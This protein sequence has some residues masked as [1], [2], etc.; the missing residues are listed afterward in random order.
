VAIHELAREHGVPFHIHVQE[1]RIQAMSGQQLY[2]M[3]MVRYMYEIGVL[4]ARTTIVHAVWLDDEDIE[5]VADSGATVVHN[6]ASNLKLGSGI[7]PIARLRKKGVPVALGTDANTCNDSQNMLEAMKLAALLSCVAS[8]NPS[9]WL[10]P[11]SALEMAGAPGSATSPYGGPRR[12]QRGEPADLVIMRRDSLAF[13]PLNDPLAQLVYGASP[14]DIGTVI[15]GGRPVVDRG[16][17]LT[18]D[19]AKHAAVVEEAAATFWEAA[20]S[21]L[22]S[23]GQLDDLLSRLYVRSTEE[24]PGSATD[25]STRH[26]ALP[27]TTA[28]KGSP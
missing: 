12:L 15:A 5:L 11:G 6:P 21:S 24:R 2:G 23:N 17:L 8:S 13:V 7:A 19:V 16:R 3:S 26:P 14:A 10:S 4:D 1:S 25:Y 20:Q 27:S 22:S 18:I 28:N 9:E